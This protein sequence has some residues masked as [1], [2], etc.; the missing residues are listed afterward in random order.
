MGYMWCTNLINSWMS[1]GMDK[2]KAESTLFSRR[3]IDWCLMPNLAIFQPYR[4]S[5]FFLVIVLSVLRFKYSE[6]HFRYLQALISNIVY[7]VHQYN[8][9]FVIN[10]QIALQKRKRYHPNN[11]CKYQHHHIRHKWMHVKINIKNCFVK[12][13]EIVVYHLTVKMRSIMLSYNLYFKV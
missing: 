13:I 10:L 4:I 3:L 11:T 12:I 8:V 6:Y 1:W 7:L 9:K 2:I 5:F